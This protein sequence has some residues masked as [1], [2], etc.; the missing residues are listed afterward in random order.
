MKQ[1]V[2]AS[3]ALIAEKQDEALKCFKK[4]WSIKDTQYNDYQI[5]K[6]KNMEK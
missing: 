5:S 4:N 6:L 2:E 1:E 3:Q